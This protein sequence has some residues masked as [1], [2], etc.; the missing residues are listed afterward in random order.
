M[1]IE[2]G[3]LLLLDNYTLLW[4]GILIYRTLIFITREYSQRYLPE[5]PESS[6]V[7]VGLTNQL[8]LLTKKSVIQLSFG[9]IDSFN[10]YVALWLCLIREQH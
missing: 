9:I 1:T 6:L 4:I 5:L 2:K 8:K 10:L 7:V 3:E